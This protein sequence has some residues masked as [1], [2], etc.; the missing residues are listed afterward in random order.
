M[1]E[2][3]IETLDTVER[4]HILNTLSLL[5]GNKAN[6]AKALGISLKTL[7]N[8]LAKYEDRKGFFRVLRK[9]ARDLK[10]KGL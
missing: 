4:K 3:I 9:L 6:T 2:L 10:K 5:N 7:Y 8:K 1:T